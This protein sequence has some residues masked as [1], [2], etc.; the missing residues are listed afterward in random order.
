MSSPNPTTDSLTIS[1]AVDIF[2]GDLRLA[3]RS[4][5]TYRIGINKFLR[6]L[7]RHEGIDPDTASWQ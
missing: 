4:R 2:F 1:A 6:H 7:A 3:P 5:T